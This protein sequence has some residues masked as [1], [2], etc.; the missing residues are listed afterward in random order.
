MD[1]WT[2][3]EDLAVGCIKTK[4]A[5]SMGYRGRIEVEL[6]ATRVSASECCEKGISGDACDNDEEMFYDWDGEQCSLTIYAKDAEG[7]RADEVLT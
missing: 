5:K 7:N 1:K 4:Y 2:W 3:S 6:E